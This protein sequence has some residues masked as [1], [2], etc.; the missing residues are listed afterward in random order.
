MIIGSLPLRR[1]RILK[2]DGLPEQ[3]REA[4]PL[5]DFIVHTALGSPYGRAVLA[6]LLE[7]GAAHRIAPVAPGAW[8]SEAH[9]SLHPFGRVPVL[10]HD[11]FVLY[12]TQAILRY[13]DRV[14]PCPALTPD[15]PR[16]AAQMDQV[17]NICDWY[18][19]QGVVN[20]IGYQR[21]VR[22]HVTRLPPDEEAV[23]QA[24]P[25]AHV[26]LDRL[27]RLLGDRPY[28]AGDAISLADLHVAPQIA[29]L[30]RTPEWA[31][32]AAPVANLAAW[33]DRM[34]ERASFRA[35]VR[36]HLAEATGTA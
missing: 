5:V 25:R 19:F 33:L 28:L 6:T 24:M 11:G 32:L 30:A 8:K 12:E 2:A 17:M 22:P 31:A 21:L 20:V 29:F 3:A 26:V 13:L 14:L 23:A 7:K 9:R 4:P 27:E 1:P 35:T 36:E 18:L 15:D 10:E 34:N 16:T